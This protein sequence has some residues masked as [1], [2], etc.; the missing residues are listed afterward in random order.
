MSASLCYQGVEKKIISVASFPSENCHKF[1][2]LEPS[3]GRME[4]SFGFLWSIPGKC[5][6]HQQK[7]STAAQIL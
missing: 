3:E 2:F 1:P 5:S 4:D 7:M 6:C